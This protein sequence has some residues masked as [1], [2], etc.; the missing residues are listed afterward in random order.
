[1]VLPTTVKRTGTVGRYTAVYV[2]GV[3]DI[4]EMADLVWRAL[5]SFDGYYLTGIDES[6][7]FDTQN[8]INKI[9]Y[10]RML[11]NNKETE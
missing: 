3:T 4:E 11:K 5:D 8:K 9:M 2:G 10:N 6:V 7:R 1:M